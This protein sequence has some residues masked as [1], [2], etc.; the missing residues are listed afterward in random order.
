MEMTNSTNELVRAQKMIS[1]KAIIALHG[2]AAPLTY[3][4]ELKRMEQGEPETMNMPD[5]W[6]ESPAS[7]GAVRGKW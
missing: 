5:D 7:V 1:L 4:E 3:V 6:W 2:S